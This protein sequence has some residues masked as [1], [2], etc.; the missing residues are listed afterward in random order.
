MA[1]SF[2]R[3]LSV[4][5]LWVALSAAPASAQDSGNLAGTA[6]N[7]DFVSGPILGSHAAVG[8]GGARTA[9]AVGSDGAIFNPASYASRGLWELDWF[10]WDLSFDF[11]PGSLRNTDFDNNGAEGFTYRD[12]VFITL[13]GTLEFG[14]LGVGAIARTQTYTI[15]PQTELTLTLLNYGAAYA[16][17]D[18]ALVIGLGGRTAALEVA[19]TAV[20]A[21]P[22][23]NLVDFGG[24]SP[25]VGVLVRPPDLP[26]RIGAAARAPVVSE[27]IGTSLETAGLTL[28]R[29]VKL[30]WEVQAGVAV[31][32]GPRPLNR[33][34][35]NPHDLRDRLQ[36]EMRDARATRMRAQ[37]EQEALE[38]GEPVG[39]APRDPAWWIEERKQRDEEHRAYRAA[40]TAAAEAAEHAYEALPRGH[41]LLAADVLLIGPSENAV[42]LE[43][44]LSQT[45]QVSGEH[46][47]LGVRGGLETEPFDNRLKL[48]LGGYLEPSRFAGVGYRPHLTTG[49]EVR[50]FRWDVF[51]LFE[52]FDVR[53]GLTF[54]FAQRYLNWIIGIGFWH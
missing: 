49:G 46:V 25:E 40:Q 37:L 38:S 52:P 16:F 9:L 39:D 28:P 34:W 1:R 41:W 2:A 22:T 51:G 10:E 47:S 23:G 32:L 5:P 21:A 7:I 42:G 6:F 36:A 18:G 8:M 45:R 20:G 44:F 35:E 48:R 12:F 19:S 30:P 26:V 50:L 17:F 11:I 54:D 3:L 14:A 27:R 43:S 33:R 13:G 4:L 24:T 53:A 29:Q 31:Q 15:G